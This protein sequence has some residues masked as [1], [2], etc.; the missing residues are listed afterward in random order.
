MAGNGRSR[1][2]KGAIALLVFASIAI[3]AGLLALILFN[4]GDSSPSGAATSTTVGNPID[5]HKARVGTAA[6]RF[7]L[8][9]I[10]GREVSLSDLRGKP[11]VIAFFASWCHPCE[12]EL[13]VLEQYAEDEGDR[14]HVVAISFRDLPS[15][16]E[17][18][19]RRLGV[20][21]PALIDEPTAPVGGRYGV[22]G[23]PQTVFID[24]DGVVRGRVY[25]VTSRD[26][27]APAIGDLLAGRD[28][29]AI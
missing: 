14:L 29:R 1:P 5:E 28:V 3:P 2:S 26:E 6:P 12:E 22:R 24:A 13:P 20:T 21:Y 11:V 8:R 25:G 18:F 15:D 27:L 23:I 4:D 17:Q 16:S 19:V 10:D 7:A 9:D